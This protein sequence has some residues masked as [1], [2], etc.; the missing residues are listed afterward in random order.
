MFGLACCLL[1]LAISPCFCFSP[2][3]VPVEVADLDPNFVTV[4]LAMLFMYFV[5]GTIVYAYVP[6]SF[7]SGVT[8]KSCSNNTGLWVNF[9]KPV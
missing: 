3:R 4:S 8:T 5:V 2:P 9:N 7:I 6:M 1:L